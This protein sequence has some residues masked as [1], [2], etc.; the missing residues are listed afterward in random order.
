[1]E[2]EDFHPIEEEV[3]TEEEV[4]DIEE[5]MDHHNDHSNKEDFN[6]EEVHIEE[7]LIHVVEVQLEESVVTAVVAADHYLVQLV[8]PNVIVEM[9]HV[10]HLNQD[11]Y[12][13]LQ[14]G[15]EGR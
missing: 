9:L 4:V 8:P 12:Q 2:D 3:D 7:D 10:L 14:K 15:T 6:K 13:D 5:D 11:L 1:M